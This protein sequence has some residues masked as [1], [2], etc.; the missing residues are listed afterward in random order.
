[1]ETAEREYQRVAEQIGGHLMIEALRVENFRSFKLLQ[2]SKLKRVN[3]IVGGNASGKTALIEAIKLGLDA[4]PGSFPWLN[5]MRGMVFIM[6]PNLTA[7]QFKE[8]FIDFFL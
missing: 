6:P 7:E 1:M 4:T 5:S 2:L 8:Q 3:I